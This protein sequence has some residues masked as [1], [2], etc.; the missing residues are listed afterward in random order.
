ME[1][2]AV[3]GLSLREADVADLERLT[4]PSAGAA[5]VDLRERADALAASELVWLATCNR[6]EVVFAREN[7]HLPCASDRDGVAQALG[8]SAR[9]PLRGR[10]HLH[11]GIDAVRYLFRVAA[12]LESAVIG[13][14]Q[15][16]AQVR[17]AFARSEA[18]GLT[19]R[20][21]GTAFEHAFQVGKLVRTRTDLARRPASVVSVGATALARRFAGARPRL[22][23]LGAGEMAA[24]FV[25]SAREHGLA[26]ALI[27]NRTLERAR[28]LAATCGAR[29][30]TLAEFAASGEAF[31]ALAAATAAPGL[32]LSADELRSLAERAPLGRGLVA[33][34]LALPRDL[35]SIEHPRLEILDL[36]RLRD[37]AAEHR[38]QRAADAAQAELLIE[39][40]LDTF[41]RKAARQVFDA[42]L[43]DVQCESSG[44]FERELAQ[45]FT[46]RLAALAEPD[47]QAIERWARAAFG[48]VSHV[49][50]NAIKRL[51]S[52]ATLFGARDGEEGRA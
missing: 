23:L 8:L 28:A 11:T 20:L 36:D 12:S 15:I 24:L 51:A 1:R 25:R 40:K 38:A 4:R 35:P 42:A 7:G 33:L 30:T 10:M 52:E 17:A 39:A 31:D 41:A 2:I 27:A 18:I 47:R 9:D 50:L 16:L 48:R 22:A 13:E 49:P 19:G 14:D 5:E 3:A 43:A 37:L 34:D 21:L 32:V 44:V 26:V 46:G 45:L 29:A 6:V